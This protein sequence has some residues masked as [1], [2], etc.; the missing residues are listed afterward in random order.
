MN[1]RRALI[2]AGTFFLGCNAQAGVPLSAG[3]DGHVTVPAYV[4]GLGPYPFVLDTGADESGVYE[5]FAK[6]KN[7]PKGKMQELGGMTGTTT[8]PTFRISKLSVDDRV[9]RDFVADGYPNRHDT[10]QQAG[11]AGNDLMDGSIVVFDFPCRTV[12]LH[13]KPFLIGSVLP[14]GAVG[15]RGGAVRAGTQLTLPVSI[16]GVEGIAVLDTGSK[17]TKINPRFASA[18]GVDTMS[19]SFRDADLIYGADSHSVASRKG[20]VKEINFAGMQVLAAEVRVVDLPVL[21]SFGIGKEPAMIL[22]IDLMRSYRLI[23]DHQAKNFWFGK[24]ECPT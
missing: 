7:L 15:L 14:K 20:P 17:D 12:E 8:A 9:I 11:V 21:D 18:A 22:G 2:C 3:T 10:G 5:W 13:A 4:N 16:N 23:Y 1:V 24:S 19:A 6:E